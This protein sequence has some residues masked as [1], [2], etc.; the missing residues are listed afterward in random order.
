MIAD[1]S[2]VLD[3]ELIT[4]LRLVIIASVSPDTDQQVPSKSR[5]RVQHEI[6]EILTEE[7]VLGRFEEEAKIRQDKKKNKPAKKTAKTTAKKTAKKT[8]GK[9]K[10]KSASIDDMF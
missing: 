2:D 9:N 1:A 5:R 4:P 7:A 10:K 8:A 3:K 6:G